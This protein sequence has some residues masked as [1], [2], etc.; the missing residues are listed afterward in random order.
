[1]FV[2]NGEPLRVGDHYAAF[3]R[4]NKTSDVRSNMHAGGEAEAVKVTD[5][6][7]RLVDTVKPKLL[8]DGMFLVGLDIVGDKLMEVN[9]FSPGGLGSA[10][11][12]EET[13]FAAAVIEALEHKV[14]LR[15]AYGHTLSNAALATL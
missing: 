1:M 13:D 9:V 8:A 6:M 7:L 11:A 2:M 4:V 14:A 15:D 5:E 3:R 12:L 10:G